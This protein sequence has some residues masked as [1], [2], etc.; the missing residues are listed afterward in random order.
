MSNNMILFLGEKTRGWFCEEF[1]HV[2]GIEMDYIK[3]YSDINEQMT[4][5]AA[6]KERGIDYIVYDINQYAGK[7][8]EVADVVMRLTQACNARPIIYAQGFTAESTL[9]IALRNAGVKAFIFSNSPAKKKKELENFV[10]DYLTHATMEAYIGDVIEEPELPASV[11]KVESNARPVRSIGVA[12]T[13]NRMGT[14]T[15]ALQIVKSYLF[16]GYKAAYIQ[17]DGSNFVENIERYFEDTH[18]DESLGQ[19]SFNHVD[20]FYNSDKL[21]QILEMDYDVYVY[22]YG[23]FGSARFNKISFL[24]KDIT[25]VVCGAK[26]NEITE[27]TKILQSAFYSDVN[28]VFS[29]VAKA[30]QKDVL[31]LMDEKADKTFFAGYSPDQ[32][33]YNPDSS[34]YQELF[35]LE[36]RNSEEKKSKFLFF[37]KKKG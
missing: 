20:M 35:S 11:E 27:T 5:V 33:T 24:E 17:L 3:A 21:S 4:L 34:F 23:V 16:L 12:G 36:N 28:Y 31:E 25:I 6:K 19:V 22:D 15:Q 37:K 26:P 30:E 29:F 2:H 14:T 13:V 8:T 7:A 10:T 9:V 18:V 32:F 1:C